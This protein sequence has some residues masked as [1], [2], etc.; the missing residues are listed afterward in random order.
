MGSNFI[1]FDRHTPYLLS[2]SL[3]DWLPEDHLARFVVDVV[4]QLDL[5]PIKRVY[6]GRGSQ[7]YHPEML[8]AL[9][10]YGYATGIYSSRKIEQATYDSVAFRFIAANTHP[11]HDTIATFRKR[12]LDK[13][14]PLFVQILMLAREMGFLKLGKVSLDGTKVKANASKHR[15]LSW[16]Y[17]CKL[18]E[19]LKAEVDELMELANQAD[20]TKIPDGMNVPEEITRREDRLVAIAEAKEK[21]EQR[22]NERYAEE[23]QKYDDKMAVREA[24]AEK[25]GKKPRGRTPQPPESG[26]CKKDQVN[27]TDE[28]S[29]IMPTSGKGFEQSYN[30]QA[31]VDIDSMLIVESHV[32]QSPNDKQEILPTVEGLTSLP[33][34]LGVVDTI[35]ADTGY[36]S[37]NNVTICNSNEMEPLI[38]VGREKHNQALKDRFCQP[39]PLSDEADPVSKMRHR[40]KT[41]EGR[42]IYAKRKCTVEPVFGI[43]KEVM[44]FR[45]FLLRGIEFVQGEWNL[46]AI[47]WNLKRMFALSR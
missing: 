15:A 20:T 27:L 41:Q 16:E 8:I 36:F 5:K 23:K 17:A 39:D 21:I 29:R 47:A 14:H 44:R 46:V 2:P 31:A 37:E 11:D 43:I 18:E 45:Q 42:Q 9:L 7:A 26:P 33:E 34:E 3:Q 30:A 38:A 24:K 22:A 19:Q 1:S 12:F 10:F 32:S 40:L 35:V 28:E 6:A 13:L 25:T 4:S